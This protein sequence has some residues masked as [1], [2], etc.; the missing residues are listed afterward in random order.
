LSFLYSF[1]LILLFFFH[2]FYVAI[3]STIYLFTYLTL[4]HLCIFSHKR[5]KG[6]DVARSQISGFLTDLRQYVITLADVV[7]R[8][9]NNDV[10][11]I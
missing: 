6:Y 3:A 10:T 7:Y 9:Q 8:P 2:L 11:Y 5:L 1:S 4:N